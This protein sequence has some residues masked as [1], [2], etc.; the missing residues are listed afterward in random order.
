MTPIEL[1]DAFAAGMYLLFSAIHV[2][3]WLKRRDRASHLWL[4]LAAAGALLVDLSGMR[5]R[6]IA[7]GQEGLLLPIANL[8]GVALVTASLFE[9][10]LSLGNRKAGRLLRTLEA[11]LVVLVLL[12]GPGGMHSLQPSF[13]LLCAALLLGSMVQ[14]ARAGR[15]GDRE[16]RA[17]AAGLVLL[18]VF[19]VLDILQLTKLVP[20]VH[21]LPIAGFAILFLISASALNSRYER[22]HNE[23]VSLRHELEHRV[24]DRTRELEEVN[25]RLAEASR[26]DALT[27]LP[28]RRG[29]M[30][31]AGHELQRSQ[32]A[33]QPLSVVMVDIDHFKQINDRHGHS[34]GDD[35]LQAAA[36]RL[37]SVVRAQDLVARWGGEEFI[38]LLPD[39]GAAAAAVAAENARAALASYAFERNGTREHIT[40][41]FGVAAHRPG[42]ELDA[43][44]AA[45][46][47]ALYRA[48]EAGRNRVAAE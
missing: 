11:V 7:P 21:G 33:G 46:D 26:T 6:A 1:F 18:I 25:R 48:K 40:A 10:V 9:L 31:V 15:D 35:L 13:F 45:A 39:T 43:T 2:D 29:F 4:A 32:R 42:R 30:D 5:L 17:V 8:G 38:M 12:I 14:A 22:E 44:I 3:L 47:A 24:A 34:G 19:L 37:R 20:A 28:N 16:A 36:S 27:G 41:S 23:L